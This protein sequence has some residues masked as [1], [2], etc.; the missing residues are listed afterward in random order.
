MRSFVI[1]VSCLSSIG[2]GSASSLETVHWFPL[3][4]TLVIVLR[5]GQKTDGPL[6]SAGLE[7]SVPRSGD[8]KTETSGFDMSWLFAASQNAYI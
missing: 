3:R 2:I 7:R 5:S 1:F 8:K 6:R 4:G